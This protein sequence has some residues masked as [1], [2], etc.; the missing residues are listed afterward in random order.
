MEWKHRHT[1]ATVIL[2]LVYSLPNLSSGWA[3]WLGSLMGGA[4]VMGIIVY[5]WGAIVQRLLGGG[6][7]ED[8]SGGEVAEAA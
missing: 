2:A 8:D 4:I 3:F 1:V 7:D 5:I 6:D